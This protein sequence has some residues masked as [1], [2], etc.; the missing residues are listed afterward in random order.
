M[1]IPGKDGGFFGISSKTDLPNL[2]EFCDPVPKL[3]VFGFSGMVE[4]L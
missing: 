1:V 3:T 4:I 2:K